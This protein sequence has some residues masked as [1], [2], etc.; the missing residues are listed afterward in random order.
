MNYFNARA[1]INEEYSYD[2]YEVG[3][4][5][6]DGSNILVE[7]TISRVEMNGKKVTLVFAREIGEY[8]KM[9][10]DRARDCPLF[11]K[12][13]KPMEDQFLVNQRLVKGQHLP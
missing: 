2:R 7:N 1:R 3:F 5:H 10:N 9:I 6:K 13:W 8:K 4:K 12:Q 11:K